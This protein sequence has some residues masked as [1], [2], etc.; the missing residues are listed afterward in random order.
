MIQ[1]ADKV[2]QPKL[3]RFRL[4]RLLGITEASAILL[5]LAVIIVFAVGTKGAWL[6]NLPYLFILVAPTGIVTIGQA[7]LLISGEV[8]LSVG[9]TYALVGLSFIFLMDLGL[10]VIA[11]V[12]LA[13]A[14]SVAMGL[15]HSQVVLKL[16]V[17]SM[18][19]TLGM[20]FLYRGTVYIMSRGTSLHFPSELKN[21][22]VIRLLGGEIL[23][24]RTSIPIL[25]LLL[26]VFVVVLSR[27]RFGNHLLAVGRD[28]ASALSCGISPDRTKTAVF[29]ICSVLA[30][31]AGIIIVCQTREIYAT[32]AT[33][34]ELETIAASVIGGCLLSGGVGSIW[35]AILGIFSLLSLKGGLIMLGAPTYWYTLFVGAILVAFLVV[36]KSLIGGLN[37][38]SDQV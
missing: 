27:T 35:G 15:I 28:P 12:L 10:S 20:M 14:M 30:G 32:T 29:V 13:V 2:G 3:P 6:Q 4:R 9:S 17:P 5:T 38:K 24:V 33:S 1:K 34:L 25:I 18:I 26:I 11:A 8:D 16:R 22:L 23:G 21:H 37:G 36:S 19:A 7:M 31:L